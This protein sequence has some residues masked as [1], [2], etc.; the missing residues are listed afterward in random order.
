[1][2]FLKIFYINFYSFILL[3]NTLSQ[4]KSILSFTYPSAIELSNG[5]IFV[6]E[7]FGIYICDHSLSYIIKNEFSFSEEDQIKNEEDYS[8]VILKKRFSYI[9]SLINYKIFIFDSEGKIVYNDSKK[10]TFEDIPK[11]YTLTPIIDEN[12]Y[13]FYI[14]GYFQNNNLK[15]NYYKY[16]K[17]QK[18]RIF[19]SLLILLIIIKNAYSLSVKKQIIDMWIYSKVSI[20]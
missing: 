6:V 8:R 9:I 18:M 2:K 3:S 13:Y 4:I 1:M 17:L 12:N 15:I 19:L 7:K 16:D 20:F 11:Y 10:I 14:I 5:N